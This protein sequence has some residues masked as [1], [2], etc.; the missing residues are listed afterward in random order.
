MIKQDLLFLRSFLSF[1][2]VLHVVICY[3][4][5]TAFIDIFGIDRRV[6]GRVCQSEQRHILTSDGF[7][8]YHL[9]TFMVIWDVDRNANLHKWEGFT[10]HNLYFSID[11]L[12][13]AL[14]MLE[15]EIFILLA[16]LHPPVY[17]TLLMMDV[18]NEMFGL[19]DVQ[20]HLSSR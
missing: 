6:K 20:E 12:E 8:V 2:I 17:L 15:P 9:F 10:L 5:T 19:D 14:C 16:Y 7:L 4:F 1:R 13:D 18:K 3:L 11:A